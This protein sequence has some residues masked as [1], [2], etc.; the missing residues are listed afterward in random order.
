MIVGLVYRVGGTASS[1]WRGIRA[2]S[3]PLFTEHRRDVV[4]VVTGAV[5]GLGAGTGEML[6]EFV[7]ELIDPWL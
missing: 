6:L 3:L 2:R 1:G 4:G 5:G 7:V